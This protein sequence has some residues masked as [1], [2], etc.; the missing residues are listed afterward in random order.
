MG[1]IMTSIHLCERYRIE[2]VDQK[3]EK[4]WKTQLTELLSQN[5]ICL[6]V[7]A[8]TGRQIQGGLFAS[9]MA[10][11][12]GVPVVWGGVHASILPAQTVSHPLVDYVVEGEGEETFAE[13]VDTM[14]SQ[15]STSDIRGV[16]SK[17]NGKPVFGGPRSFIKLDELPQIPYHLV[18]LK[19]YIFPAIHGISLIL[20][21]SRGCPQRCRFCYN[22]GF[23][24][25]KWRSFSPER[26]VNDIK[27][28]RTQFPR[29]GHIQ[30]WDDNF[31]VNLSRAREIAERLK[32]L[33]PAVTWWVVGAHITDI[34]KMDDEYL[35]CLRDSGLRELFIGVESGSQ[36]ILD[37][38]HKKLTLDNLFI[39]NTRLADFGMRPTYSFLSAIPG[40]EEEDI[41]KTIEV[42]FRLKRE[43]PGIVLGNLK[44]FI[45][46]PGTPLFDKAVELGFKPPEKLEEWAKFEW[47]NYFKR[48]LP[49]LSDKRKKLLLQLYYY[50]VLMN[51]EYYLINSKFFT[52]VVSLLRPIAEMRV[53][54]FWFH[55]P[56]EARLM[57]LTRR[58]IE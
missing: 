56:L 46:F 42:M 45:C 32:Q 53:K 51:P 55:F 16:W 17:G 18:D 52:F 27:H 2:I 21:T 15:E 5:P 30:F 1:L 19:K 12:R 41:Q 29:V 35:A 38:I 28:L 11:N 14:A 23:N 47:W 31:F 44:P 37:I 48:D 49:W 7:S 4:H 20:Y 33:D 34:A 22:H 50:T 36:K 57:H 40:E 25:S 26:V 13:L 39:N 10:K 54:N 24:K 43:N 3:V 6:G 58:M 8:L 9:Q